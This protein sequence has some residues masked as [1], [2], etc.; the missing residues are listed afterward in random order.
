MRNTQIKKE[1]DNLGFKYDPNAMDVE[2]EEMFSGRGNLNSVQIKRND[3]LMNE[4]YSDEVDEIT[5]KDSWKVISAYFNQH[6][7][8]SQQ[9]GS[10]NQ[11]IDKNI[12]EIIDENK[13]IPI[14]PD[15]SYFYKNTSNHTSYELNFGQAHIAAHPQFLESNS[16]TEHIIFPN[17]AR[18][19]NLDYLS[20]LSVDIKFIE[21]S[22][23]KDDGNYDIVKE[24][25][26]NK[27]SIGKIPIMVRSKYCSLKDRNDS[28]RID[29]KECEFDQG[30]Y[31]IIGGGEKVIVAQE[32]MATNFVYVF[33]KNEQSGYS[34]QA[35]IRSNVDGL[36]RPPSQFSVKISKKNVLAKNDLGG[37]ITARIP[38]I[39]IDVPI[40][41]L[42]R[43]LG[44]IS[45]KDIMDYITF[46]END[47]SFRELL[48]PSLEY[49]IDYREKEECLEF[50]GNKATRG[51]EKS[52]K[53]RI[54]RAEEIL[55]KDM[56]PHVSI[57][58]GNEIK[59]A[60]FIGYMIFRL[61]NCALGRSY[62]DDRDH[63][64]KKRLDMSGVL[65]TGIFRQL[66]RR[67]TKK[68]EIVMKDVLKRVKTGRIQLENYIDKKMITQ[69]MKYA[70]A[71]GNWGQNR[72]GQVQKTGVAQVLQR[73]TFMSS[74][75]HLRRLNTP[76]QKTGKITKPRQLHNTHWGMLCP[77]ETPEGQACGLVKNLSLMTFVSVGTPSKTIKEIL[78]NYAEFQKLSEVQPYSIRGKSKIFINGSWIG[79]TDK[80]ETIMKGLINQR[81]RAILSK[82]ISIVNSFKN[83]EI[84]IYTDSGRTQRPLFI[85]ENH[86]NM[87]GLNELRLKITKNNIQDLENKKINFDEL[88]NN[89]IIEYLDVEEEEVSM[90]AMKI[91]DL[92]SHKDYCSTYTHCEIHPAMILG[93]SASIIPF[94][95]HNQSPRNVYQ[96]AM[97]KQA[98]GVYCSNFNLR[99]DTLAH[100]LF[101]PQ[102][103]LV[104]TQSMEYLKFKDLPAGINAIVA[105]MCY[106]GY[107]QED[108]VIMNQS[109]I[110]RGMFRTA[111]FRTYIAE[112]KR[113]ARLKFETIEVPDRQDTMG[114]RHGV[115]SKLDCEGLIS[116][117]T[118]VSGDDIIIGKTGLIK[119]EDDL[120]IDVDNDISNIS[121]RKQDISEAIRPN[122]NGVIESVMLTTDRQGFKLAKVKTRSIRIP[123]IGD[124]FASRHGQKG[125]IGMTYSQEDLPFTLEGITPDIVV[126]PHAIPSRMTIGHLIECLGSKVSALR[127]FES[128]ATPFTDVTVDSISEDL[129]KLGYQ[130]YGN[131]AVFNGFTGRKIDMMIFFGPTYYQRLKHMVEDKIFSR[132]R[133]PLQIL[134]RQPTEGRA[135]NGGLRFGEMERDCMISHGAALFL[136]ER[137]VDV[138]D[139]YRI[140]VCKNCGLIAQSDL[141]SQKFMCRLCNATDSDIAQVYIPYACKLLFQELLAMHITPRIIVGNLR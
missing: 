138:S 4:E 100:L 78:D 130:K 26:I 65:L 27:L 43:A 93:V 120:E 60:Y 116:P 5:D 66:F 112:E 63:Y 83:R 39:K 19:R 106:T 41:I 135:R 38:Y 105:I 122:E 113:E 67:F 6:G 37:L 61:G 136:K 14:E 59:K 141:N 62:G 126:N 64:G 118:R 13:S 123:Q 90:I 16:S 85:V 7:L 58:K 134:T 12:Q 49:S 114:I 71:T 46:D 8:V 101:Y 54:K 89:G 72:I 18:V 20:E 117:G 84:R 23:N 137:L 10:F 133:G 50:I 11:F 108:S 87:N 79:I 2:E 22:F 44:I 51:E 74:L 28:E 82:E 31:F 121:K 127:G 35:E 131:E 102:R 34:W 1:K 21:K 103:P 119:M 99:M 29:V 40:V 33:D 129:H 9:I 91:S 109:S 111:F 96:S 110:D 24:H 17:E 56:L 45:D 48:R 132:A 128:D 98:I 15:K 3:D 81:R 97:G 124:K 47:N 52:R 77:A 92:T 80:P 69:G 57:E 76:L 107:N 73:L 95:D 25:E 139:K 53:D 32:R 75:S 70:L 88:V 86:E 115:Y 42:F 140:H 68:T 55:R 125:T 94:P 30:G 36:N 104:V